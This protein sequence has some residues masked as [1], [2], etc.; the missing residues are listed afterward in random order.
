MVTSSQ[1]GKLAFP[2]SERG[3]TKF[4][5]S[6]VEAL[7]L[8]SI[9]PRKRGKRSPF[10]NYRFPRTSRVLRFENARLRRK[11]G[12]INKKGGKIRIFLGIPP[13]EQKKKKVLGAEGKGKENFG[14]GLNTNGKPL[15]KKSGKTFFSLRNNDEAREGRASEKEEILSIC[16]M[17]KEYDGGEGQRWR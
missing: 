5:L 9:S 7:L 14:S 1:T 13:R 12:C 4:L 10:R 8:P 15:A 16:G 3:D 2:G 17:G 11:K 6:G